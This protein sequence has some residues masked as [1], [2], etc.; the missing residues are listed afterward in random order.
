MPR[1]NRMT[2]NFFSGCALLA[3]GGL[4]QPALAADA[5]RIAALNARIA[6]LS[7][8]AERLDDINNVKK[9]QRAYGYYIDKGYWQ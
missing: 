8:E 7:A 1:M 2:T 9:L 4:C 3:A 6:T 5:A